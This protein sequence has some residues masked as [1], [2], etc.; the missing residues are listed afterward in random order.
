MDTSIAPVK[1]TAYVTIHDLEDGSTIGEI[2]RNG[3]TES[4]NAT[5]L[6]VY[7]DSTSEKLYTDGTI[8]IDE[9]TSVYVKVDGEYVAR[10]IDGVV[11]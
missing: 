6:V 11:Q 10:V 3:S 5:K 8:V 1:G 4:Y 9:H 7:L 2:T